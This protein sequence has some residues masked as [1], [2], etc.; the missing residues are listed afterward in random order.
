MN[1]LSN[2]QAFGRKGNIIYNIIIYF[3]YLA[4]Q[5]SIYILCRMNGSISD[6]LF[7]LNKRKT[8]WE[9]NKYKK[10]YNKCS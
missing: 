4:G 6:W 3:K 8:Y 9:K 5:K 1:L 2:S 7:F 10:E